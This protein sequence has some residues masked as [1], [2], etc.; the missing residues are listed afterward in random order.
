MKK[1]ISL[2]LVLTLA[3]SL[4]SF[5]AVNAS[6]A[7]SDTPAWTQKADSKIYFYANPELWHDFND[8]C[9]YV[10][11]RNHGEFFPWGSKKGKMTNEGGN[12]WSFDIAAAGI[13][14]AEN[15]HYGVTFSTDWNRQTQDLIIGSECLGDMAYAQKDE[16]IMSADPDH[17]SMTAAWINADPAKYG[18]PVHISS[19][20]T[21]TGNA[22]WDDEDAYTLF[23]RFL[24][25]P[26]FQSRIAGID[27]FNGET[28]LETAEYTANSLNLST[29]DF[30]R[31]LLDAGVT[32]DNYESPFQNATCIYFEAEPFFMEG[33]KTV[34]AYIYE[35]NG[36]GIYQW[37]SK[38]CNM[39]L[40]DENTWMYDLTKHNF[41][42]L[43]GKEY[44]VIFTADWKAG[45]NAL[46][47]NGHLRDSAF[48]TG[49]IVSGS[50]SGNLTVYEADWRQKSEGAY[51]WFYFDADEAI[52][53]EKVTDVYAFISDE[54]G[55]GI[56]EEEHFENY[57]MSYE[58]ESYWLFDLSPYHAYALSPAKNYFVTFYI[59]GFQ[60]T[61]RTVPM[62]VS[63]FCAGDTAR[64]TGS[65]VPGSNTIFEAAWDK[66]ESVTVPEWTRRNDGKIYFFAHPD[67]LPAAGG[68]TA[69]IYQT[70][71]SSLDTTLLSSVAM[72]E[73]E[74]QP[75][76]WSLDVKASGFSFE[77]G[78]AYS[79]VFKTGAGQTVSAE[80]QPY[81]PGDMA[82]PVEISETV[83]CAVWY[84]NGNDITL[85]DLN[86]DG[87]MTV[88]D[89]TLLQQYLAE[90]KN[91]SGEPI[92]DAFALYAADF[93]GDGMV[94]IADATDMQRDLAEFE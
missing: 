46:P 36:D 79:I 35:K 48:L 71:V 67:V 74:D 16:P 60:S 85:G 12:I 24:L 56:F 1:T 49:N 7:E 72:T 5:T 19:A 14:F 42:P 9:V 28:P 92:L 69:E 53:G 94:N 15:G 33:C 65:A 32:F 41:A 66:K 44:E 40:I 39:E 77:P 11:E 23:V 10:F 82:Y 54:S 81:A 51:P 38:Q 57:R 45:T 6:A 30:H 8:V 2:L 73:E 47:L 93:N 86:N 37:G 68:V 27:S 18:M 3:L 87:E 84:H 21:V 62:P 34:S 29:D 50:G 91:S 59:N 31:A 52:I 26:S 22:Y 88:Q 55:K 78:Y 43:D 17:F 70:D 75:M 83:I 25:S 64:L 58:G 76:L 63:A 80:L 89:V 13:N 4:F 90:Y 20:G 61:R